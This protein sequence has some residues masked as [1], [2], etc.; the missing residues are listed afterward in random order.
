MT[1][2]S[3]W[4]CEEMAQL[5]FWPLRFCKRR[6]EFDSESLMSSYIKE[7]IPERPA[8]LQSLMSQNVTV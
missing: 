7:E 8:A 3:F 4:L 1:H 2:N 5:N 6:S